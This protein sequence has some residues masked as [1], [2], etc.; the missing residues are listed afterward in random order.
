MLRQEWGGIS[1]SIYSEICETH[2]GR[3]SRHIQEVE[4]CISMAWVPESSSHFHKHILIYAPS[5]GW[6]KDRRLWNRF[7]FFS[8]I[9]VVIQSDRQMEQLC[10]LSLTNL[11]VSFD[12]KLIDNYTK[13]DS[14]DLNIRLNVHCI[15]LIPFSFLRQA[16]WFQFPHHKPFRSWVV[17]FHHRRPMACLSLN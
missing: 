17:I 8:E 10:P 14:E 4:P 15:F 12:V 9:F 11:F 13:I 2:G 6:L 1:H 16:R 3:G 7:G 5:G